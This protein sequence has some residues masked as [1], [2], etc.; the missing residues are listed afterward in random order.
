VI[1]VLGMVSCTPEFD[2]QPAVING[3]SQLLADVSGP[4]AGTSERS[5]VGVVSLPMGIPVESEA[6]FELWLQP[7]N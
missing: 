3:C 1:K 5:A 2:E 6:V 4:E 7:P